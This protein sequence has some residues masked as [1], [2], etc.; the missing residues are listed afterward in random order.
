ME[1]IFPGS[2]VLF[3]NLGELH[4]GAVIS[5]DQT[6]FYVQISDGTILQLP[7]SRFCLISKELIDPAVAEE[8][9]AGFKALLN[10]EYLKLDAEKL[11]E[12]IHNQDKPL[13]FDELSILAELVSD[14]KRFAA[15]YLLKDRIDLF[16]RKKELIFARNDE[17]RARLAEHEQIK[18]EREN[19]LNRVALIMKRIY[20]GDSLNS[21]CSV[22]DSKIL[23]K[24]KLELSEV[25][26]Y[27]RHSDLAKLIRPF[28]TNAEIEDIILSL[29]L[30]LGDIDAHTD[31]II[32][33]SGLP[34][35][36]NFTAETPLAAADFSKDTLTQ[37]FT[38][39][40]EDT[41]DFDDAISFHQS[42]NGWRLGIHISD[43]AETIPLGS[44][45]YNEAQRRISSLYLPNE[46]I[47]LFPS[48]I[49]ENTL[50]LVKGAIRPVISLSVELNTEL[51]ILDWSFRRER[52]YIS[53]NLSYREVDRRLE[54]TPFKDLIRLARKLK[55][56]RG[57]G[58]EIGHDRYAW[59]LKLRGG[60]IVMKRT[61]I[62]SPAR[63]LIEELMVLYNSCFAGLASK[64]AVPLIYR[65]VSQFFAADEKEGSR[66]I[67]AQAFLSTTPQFHPGIGSRAYVHASSPIRRFNDLINQYQF[68]ALLQN[69][70]AP[71]SASDLESLI[72]VIEKRVL[73]IREILPRIEHYWLL[74]FLAQD[75]LHQALDAVFIKAYKDYYLVE[76]LPW[77]KRINVFCD[78]YPPLLQEL[79][80]VARDI[81]L[82]NQC[83]SV[84]LIL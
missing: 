68:I 64:H 24:L 35:N 31:P 59:H 18:Q 49:T 8:S 41:L 27:H 81:D 16:Y 14:A 30:A 73:L 11:A 40:D 34:V 51:V 36:F 13:G 46:V 45:L 26:L 77:C 43:T 38:I 28:Q 15:F 61:D 67:G 17:E 76:L 32:A 2:L 10:S 69:A 63:M 54:Q 33:R 20:A 84:D 42:T 53:E 23:E 1:S 78:A 70:P 47:P 66:Q 48:G 62:H 4:L 80:I 50:S 57:A 79:K 21:I 5:A 65:N 9:L 44:V 39:D 6:S 75:Y 55:S 72:P 29:R 3:Y 19:Y 25:L 22:F 58:D 7:L 37:A 74:R 12:L 60:K 83:M 82:E 56:E 71:F 52:V